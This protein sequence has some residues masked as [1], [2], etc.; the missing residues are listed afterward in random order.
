MYNNFFIILVGSILIIL[1]YFF[2]KNNTYQS[3][4]TLSESDKSRPQNKSSNDTTSN[5]ESTLKTLPENKKGDGSKK[6]FDP[7][8]E[9]LIEEEKYYEAYKYIDDLRMRNIEI[10]GPHDNLI[11]INYTTLKKY[12]DAYPILLEKNG[13]FALAHMLNA[14]IV[15]KSEEVKTMLEVLNQHHRRMYESV[16]ICG[17]YYLAYAEG[18]NFAQVEAASRECVK[19]DED[20]NSHTLR[21]KSYLLL[22][23]Q[24]DYY[25]ALKVYDEI[26]PQYPTLPPFKEI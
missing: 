12:V 11:K 1:W 13:S 10:M 22:L 6:L 18:A 21:M 20:S 24:E 5:R 16:K 3:I 26:A 4:S 14:A 2:D 8:V 23:K 15:K 19:K 25:K 9:S 17:E 7:K